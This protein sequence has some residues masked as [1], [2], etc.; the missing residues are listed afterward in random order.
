MLA[1]LTPPR[2]STVLQTSRASSA[3]SRPRRPA[4][5]PAA[6][7]ISSQTPPLWSTLSARAPPHRIQQGGANTSR[8]PARRGW[9]AVLVLLAPLVVLVVR[10]R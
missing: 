2:L 8:R 6:A 10:L 1:P 5:R 9:V 7:S 4:P 3:P